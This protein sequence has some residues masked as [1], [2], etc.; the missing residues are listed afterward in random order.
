MVFSKFSP[1]SSENPN[2]LSDVFDIVL[3]L[4]VDITTG[5]NKKFKHQMFS[6]TFQQT[7]QMS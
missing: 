1:F 3:S 4:Q 2:F 7:L 6:D 5:L